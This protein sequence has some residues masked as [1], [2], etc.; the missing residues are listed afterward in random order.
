M[1]K[2]PNISGSFLCSLINNA[3]TALYVLQFFYDKKAD[4]S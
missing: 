4:Q 3:E 1:K 2:L